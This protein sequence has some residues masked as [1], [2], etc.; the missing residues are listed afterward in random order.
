MTKH[1]KLRLE[2]RDHISVHS[3][4]EI[5]DLGLFN[6][7]VK[8]FDK[9]LMRGVLLNIVVSIFSIREFNNKGMRDSI[10]FR[11]D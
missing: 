6:Q 2:T 9:A 11:V 4:S 3:I 7:P 8:T 5:N 10:L 1:R